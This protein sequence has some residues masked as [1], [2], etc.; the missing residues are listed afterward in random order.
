MKKRIIFLTL[1]LSIIFSFQILLH[2]QS[3]EDL[4][5]EEALQQYINKN[6][7]RFGKNE[8]AR[9]RFLI[10]QMRDINEE[11]K[12]RIK[13]VGAKRDQYFVGL[14]NRLEELEALRQ[15]LSDYN[16]AT[17]NAFIDQL[18]NRIRETIDEGEINYR[19]QKI[20]EDGIQVLYIAEE[21]LKLDPG[22]STQLN[23]QLQASNQKLLNSFGDAG[24]SPSG[25]PQFSSQG[26]ATIWDL[27]VEWQR[28]NR[29]QYEARWT[30][31]EIIKTR[32]LKNG[33]G[34]EKDRMFKR[35]LRS[36]VLA[37]NYR[38]FD[39]AD[40]L[41]EEILNKYS[42]LNTLDDVYFYKGEANYQLDRYSAA[43]SSYL[44]LT[45]KYPTSS[46]SV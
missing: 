8:I 32:L 26:S 9:E 28:T 17:L 7:L 19:R 3:A 21:M 11:I 29:L 34:M 37:Y 6:L 35:E 40:R 5:F 27:F 46:L 44:D 20:F 13:N 41:F 39:L 25:A 30:D 22:A 14:L 45:K 43:T 16:S 38:N 12:S 33:T 2:A 31:I 4:K 24:K 10:Q 1:F 18:D 36:A 23:Q 42:F 15:R